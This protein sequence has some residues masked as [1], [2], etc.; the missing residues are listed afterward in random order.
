MSD[1]V[2]FSEDIDEGM[3]FLEHHQILG[4]KWGVMNGPPYPL[5]KGDHSSSEKKAAEAAGV[6]VGSDSGKGSID[7]VQKKKKNSGV[8]N[9]PKKE[10]T[11]EEKR[12]A[13]LEAV[14]SGD[15]K[16]IAKYMD[17]LTTQEL[18]EAEARV[19]AKGNITRE[20][21]G[22]KKASKVEM[23][24]LEAI[25]S[26]DKE[27]VKQYADQMSYQELAE[28]MNKI[29]LT[30][31]LNYTAP[32]KSALDKLSEVAGKVDQFK[33][34][35]EKGIGMYNLAAKVYNSTH[36]DGAQW[37]IIENPQQKQPQSQ[38]QKVAQQLMNQ[39][40]N[41]VKKT[42]QQNQQQA[43]Q[44]SYKEQ[45]DEALKNAKIDYKN[46]QKFEAW[47]EKQET[48][49]AEKKS[50]KEETTPKAESK[51][52]SKTQQSN[53]EQSSNNTQQTTQKNYKY[54]P[55]EAPKVKASL[56]KK[57]EIELDEEQQK[58]FDSERKKDD[59][60]LEQMKAS[61]KTTYDSVKDTPISSYDKKYQK[62]IEDSFSDIMNDYNESVR[63]Q[64]V[65]AQERQDRAQT[66]SDAKKYY[67][68]AMY[69]NNND[70][71]RYWYQVIL[72]NE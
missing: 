47:K 30:Q 59:A 62:D 60:Y 1:F 56:F 25:R 12:A 17:Q 23:E 11:P 65:T 9:K 41:D 10:L 42:A 49:K 13:A 43:Q 16:K 50:E 64:Q 2:A 40:I 58:I 44:K 31:R 68:D 39:A 20:E 3:K 33:Q 19:R 22:E 8:Q 53:Q 32:P 35:A 26:G 48:K 45:S 57:K 15:K 69:E 4:A 34:A 52:E 21:P 55:T 66:V 29:D 54:T 27:K 14:K 7:N 6:K 67:R 24:K 72:N 61:A 5:G 71:A 18:Q 38:E 28:A 51:E 37:P 70:A 36:K 46:Q 63:R